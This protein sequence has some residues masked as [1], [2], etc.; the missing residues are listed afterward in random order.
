MYHDASEHRITGDLVEH[1]KGCSDTHYCAEATGTATAMNF[2]CETSPYSQEEV[3]NLSTCADGADSDCSTYSWCGLA[4][5]NGLSLSHSSSSSSLASWTLTSPRLAGWAQDVSDDDE[6]EVIARLAD[7]DWSVVEELVG[8]MKTLRTS[9]LVT[10]IMPYQ[11]KVTSRR[12][13]RRG[14]CRT[15]LT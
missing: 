3:V 14:L 2:M 4:S 7:E 10:I 8:P 6:G 11:V 12:G 1:S 5:R 9:A 15:R 13:G